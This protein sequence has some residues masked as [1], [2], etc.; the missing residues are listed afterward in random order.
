MMGDAHLGGEV[1]K[2]EE[3]LL[4]CVIDQTWHSSDHW[5]RH[6]EAVDTPYVQMDTQRTQAGGGFPST[7]R[8]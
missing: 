4:F 7:T 6:G 1:R 3:R 2:K 5:G 8:Y